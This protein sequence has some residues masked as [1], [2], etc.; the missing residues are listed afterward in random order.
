[1]MAMAIFIACH[2]HVS[3]ASALDN[4]QVQ[5]DQATVNALKSSRTTRW[6]KYG[7]TEGVEFYADPDSVKRTG[8][9]V[10]VKELIDNAKPDSDGSQSSIEIMAYDCANR[11]YKN[12]YS[13]KFSGHMGK[14]SVISTNSSAKE[15]GDVVIGTVADSA[16]NFSCNFAPYVTPLDRFRKDRHNDAYMRDL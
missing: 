8:H 9:V 1:M 4:N 11:T 6:Q 16:Y 14:G 3:E 12:L 10:Y 5:F 7:F 13:T 2:L 15:L